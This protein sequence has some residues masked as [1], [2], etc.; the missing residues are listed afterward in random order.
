MN[1]YRNC[2]F[3]VPATRAYRTPGS[4]NLFP[5]HC[6]LPTL[7]ETEHAEEV[8][9]KLIGSTIKMKRK[10]KTKLLGKLKRAIKIVTSI[11]DE[12]AIERVDED[13]DLTPNAEG[14]VERVE[15]P[16][17]RVPTSPAITT[18]TNPID[19]RVIKTARP[20]TQQ[21][22]TRGNKP[23]RLPNIVNSRGRQCSITDDT[24][25]QTSESRQCGSHPPSQLNHIFTSDA[26]GTRPHHFARD[27]KHHH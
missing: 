8:M 27:T 2:E 17:Q 3:Y 9:D 18:S 21:R 20:C 1:H 14:D 6:Q 10:L 7:N 24:P 5:Q 13:N 26:N 15:E 19:A 25:L 11:E 22:H 12:H 16:Q 4:S 23:G